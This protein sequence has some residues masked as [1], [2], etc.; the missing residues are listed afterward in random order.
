M[1]DGGAGNGG[2]GL[3]GRL[4]DW[5]GALLGGDGGSGVEAEAADATAAGVCAVCGTPVEDP[6][7]GCPLCGSTDVRPPDGSSASTAGADE[8]ARL[9][10]DRRS[11]EGTTDDAVTRLSDLR[12]GEPDAAVGDPE[13][14]ENADGERTT[15][16]TDAPT[17]P[18]DA[19]GGAD[20]D[21][22]AD[23]G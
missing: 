14:P 4:R 7:S 8:S 10:P 6:G 23:D 16:G 15:D 12:G 3:L 2:G 5:L 1:T 11:V 18:G 9:D 19:T 17:A 13:G 21:R 20:G 22:P